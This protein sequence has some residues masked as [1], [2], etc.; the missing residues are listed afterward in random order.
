MQLHTR[1]MG[2]G[3]RVLFVHGSLTTS[4]Q[5][6]EKQEPLA[7]RWTLVIPDRRGYA[8][9][10]VAER[11]DFEEDAADIAPL[12]DR[13]THLVGHSYGAIVALT[14]PDALPKRFARSRWSRP[15][16]RHWC[17][18]SLRSRS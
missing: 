7:E 4:R 16:R 9:N 18:V 6:W 10:A 12:L 17:A 13:G 14:L 11:S 2:T 1:V 15:L 3:P 5:S 8:P